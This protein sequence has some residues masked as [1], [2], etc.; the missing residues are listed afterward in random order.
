MRLLPVVPVVLALFL[1]ACGGSS[2]NTVD[3]I[4]VRIVTLPNGGKIRAESMTTQIELLKGMMFRES[5]AQDRGMLF[6]HPD[7][8]T[9]HYWMFQ[10]K[11]PL[12]IIWMDRDR[13][14]VEVSQNTPPC[15]TNR[16]KD[17]PNYGGNFPS[18]YV[19]EVNA[20][21]VAKNGLQVG[22]RLDF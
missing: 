10:C 12:D 6:T 5:L 17:C 19:L 8:G 11:I 2:S 16:A 14:I 22:N 13:R 18:R 4:G 7:E 3:E 20:G 1:T 21:F 15:G 9:Y